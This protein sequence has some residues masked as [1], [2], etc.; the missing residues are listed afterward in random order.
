[1]T[2]ARGHAGNGPDYR[3]LRLIKAISTGYHRLP[4]HELPCT[5]CSQ[6]AAT[7]RKPPLPAYDELGEVQANAGI[8]T[9]PL[10]RPAPP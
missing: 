5:S 7:G 2:W 10:H 9:H 8:M 6:S 4:V 3:L 1:M